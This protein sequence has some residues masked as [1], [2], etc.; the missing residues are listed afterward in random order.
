[1]SRISWIATTRTLLGYAGWMTLR[2]G[3]GGGGGEDDDVGDLQTKLLS[4]SSMSGY[5]RVSG[6]SGHRGHRADITDIVGMI[7]P[8]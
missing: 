1:M 7:C 6:G 3:D 5:L 2:G 4:R 8:C